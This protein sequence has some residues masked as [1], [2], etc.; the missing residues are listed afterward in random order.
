MLLAARPG[1]MTPDERMT[2]DDA[3]VRQVG[4][5]K[6]Q[7]GEDGTPDGAVMPDLRAWRAEQ[8]RRQ[9]A[10]TPRGGLA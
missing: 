3:T 7:H 2:P 9:A 6:K 1:G 5:A 4:M 10:L 8:Q